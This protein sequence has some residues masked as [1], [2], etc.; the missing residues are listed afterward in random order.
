MYSIYYLRDLGRGKTILHT[1]LGTKQHEE[2]SDVSRSI[3]VS[4]IICKERTLSLDMGRFLNK[5]DRCRRSALYF[6]VKNNL[7]ACV[8]T[9]LNEGATVN[10]QCT[11]DRVTPVMVAAKQGNVTILEMLLDKGKYMSTYTGV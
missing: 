4:C 6:A 5:Q 1:I 11:A 9:L 3:V 2:E 7:V 10:I 8:R